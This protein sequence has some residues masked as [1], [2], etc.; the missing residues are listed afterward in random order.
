M[1]EIP[2]WEKYNLTFEEAAAYFN[3]GINKLRELAKNECYDCIVMIGNKTLLKR[4]KM[5][6][7]IDQSIAL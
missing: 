5:K 1:I 4:E 6:E 3:I 2:I 7:F